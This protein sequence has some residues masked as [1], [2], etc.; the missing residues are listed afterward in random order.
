MPDR[1]GQIGSGLANVVGRTAIAVT[2]LC[3][4]VI[5]ATAALVLS[6][7]LRD[8]VGLESSPTAGYAI[9]DPI[10]LPAAWRQAS[11]PT[12]A[13]FLRGSCPTCADS[14]PLLRRLAAEY[15]D[16]PERILF[17]IGDSALER[18]RAFVAE[19]GAERV[20]EVDFR[21]LRLA[22]VPTIVVFDS[23]GIITF[24]KSGVIAADDLDAARRLLQPSPGR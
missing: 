6:P 14:A 7:G 13:V 22:R 2:A 18:D 8:A 11:T 1:G 15:A 17:V 19:L 10:D 23:R 20:A 3:V 12:L 4:V 16:R 9:G 5:F 24:V 21:Q